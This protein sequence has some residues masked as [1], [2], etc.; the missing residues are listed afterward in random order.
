[1][2]PLIQGPRSR[3][4]WLTNVLIPY[5]SIFWRSKTVNTLNSWVEKGGRCRSWKWTNKTKINISDK[6]RI[7]KMR[8]FHFFDLF[9]I[10]TFSVFDLFCI[11]SFSV[12]DLF[13]TF[14]PFLCFD[15]LFSTFSGFRPFHS[16]DLIRLRPLAPKHQ[17]VQFVTIRFTSSKNYSSG[18]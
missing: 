18:P 5:S 14:R 6:F 12:F 4:F 10:S 1:M 3:F 8:R 13:S 2:S 9:W 17:F 7:P 16:F 15:L 11:S